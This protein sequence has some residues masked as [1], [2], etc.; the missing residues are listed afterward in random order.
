MFYHFYCYFASKCSRILLICTSRSN[1]AQSRGSS[2]VRSVIEN[3]PAGTVCQINQPSVLPNSRL[4]Q[5]GAKTSSAPCVP[6]SSIT[7]LPTT[8]KSETGKVQIA[9]KPIHRH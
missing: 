4:I 7:R 6:K 3:K 9:R 1:E 5:S 8:V 2:G